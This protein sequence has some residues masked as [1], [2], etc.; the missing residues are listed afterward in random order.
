[1]KILLLGSNGM[2]G[3]AVKQQLIESECQYTSVDR[4]GDGYSF[5]LLNDKRLEQCIE[6]VNPDVIINTAAIVNL[7]QCE[8]DPGGAYC[9]NTRLPGIL[10]EICRGRD[11]YL[12]HISTDHY[13]TGDGTRLHTEED[14]IKL[15]NEY[16]RTKYIGEQMALM[17]NNTVVL[18]TNIVGFRARGTL[19]FLEWAISQIVQNKAMV[20]FNDFYTS[21]IHTRDFA[22]VLMDI[23]KQRPLGIYNLA[24]SDVSSKKE[25]II[26]LSDALFGCHPKYTVGSVKKLNGAP[27]AE[28]LGLSTEKIENI[29]GYKMPTLDETIDSIKMEYERRKGR[30]ELQYLGID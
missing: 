15:I 20:L 11:C 29:V 23:L 14:E 28:S 12:V 26:E 7:E 5:D 22:K 4:A 30:N 2:L 1:M 25:F 8:G 13:Y 24:S 10:A 19:T 18:R 16:A 3:Q 17:Y 9:L 27:R 21:T 6:E